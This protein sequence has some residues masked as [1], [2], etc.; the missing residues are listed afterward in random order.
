[1]PVESSAN[2]EGKESRCSSPGQSW[3]KRASK[4]PGLEKDQQSEAQRDGTQGS[5]G[6]MGE[7]EGESIEL[8]FGR[9]I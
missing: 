9:Q 4:N 7:R 5:R 3:R 2:G 8:R 1:M 6:A